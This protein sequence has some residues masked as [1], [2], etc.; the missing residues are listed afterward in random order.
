MPLFVCLIHEPFTN[1][2]PSFFYSQQ[3]QLDPSTGVPVTEEMEDPVSPTP[4]NGSRDERGV[5][6]RGEP[7][8]QEYLFYL[9]E[10]DVMAK[11]L[12]AAA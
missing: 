6:G 2:L 11:D 12:T 3:L 7:S 10:L 5:R 8:K 1:N 9:L 4:R